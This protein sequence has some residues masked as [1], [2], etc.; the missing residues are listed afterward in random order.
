MATV[1]RPSKSLPDPG[2]A[3][4]AEP[5]RD[6]IT[7]ILAFLESTNIDEGNVDLTGSD[8]IL[9][10]ST[11]Q[12]ATGLKTWGQTTAASA[13]VIDVAIFQ[14][15][16]SSGTTSDNQGMR[17]SFKMDDDAGNL[18]EVG[19]IDLVETDVSSTTEDAEWQFHA[20]AAG[21]LTKSLTVSGTGTTS[22]LPLTV[23][24]NDTGHDVKFFGASSGAYMEWDESADQLRIMGAS[25]DATTS[26]GKLL[27]ATSLTDINAN[28]VLGKI[29][30]QA[31]HE[32][33]GTD[34]ITVAASI[35]AIAQGTF[36][37]G[38][39]ATDLIFY[40][41]HSEAATEKIRITSQGEIGI[42]GANYGSDGQVLTSGGAGA[43]PAWEDSTAG[44]ITGV[45]AG[46]GLSGGGT[47]G[48]V[49]LTVEAAQTVITSLLATDIKIGED[50]ETKIDFET[51]DE[52]HFFAADTE[53][54]YLADNIFGP[55]SDSDV[56]LG[57][58]GV[59][60]KDAFVDS[61]TVT[62]EVDGATL[63]ISG[64]ADIDG[65]TN[66]DAVDIDGAVQ[67]DATVSVGVDDQGYDVKF[68]GDTASAYLLWDTSADKLLTAGGASIDIVKDKLLIGGTAVTTTAAE[69]NVLDA[70]TGGTVAASKAVVVDSYKDVSSFR[71]VTL[72]G[73]LTTGSATFGGGYGDT[74]AT[75]SGAGVIQANGAITSDAAVTGATLVG[76]IS[77]AAQNSITS[78]S[79]L[80]TVGTMPSGTWS[81][82]IDGSCTMTLGSDATGDIYYRD[83]SGHLER[84]ASGADGYVLT[85]TGAG[86][87]PAWEAAT[88]GDITGVTAG[89]GLSGGG[90][91]GGVTLNIEAAQT[92]ITS[93]LA[94]DI[95][96]GEDD[97]TKIDFET[98]DEI[99][100]FAADT[101]QVYL[102]DNIFGPQSDSDVDLGTTGV[103]WKD[104][105]VDSITVTGEVDGATL[106][107]SGNADID[108]IT[109]LDAVDIDGAVQIDA[110]VS[111]GVDD[112]G[113]DV[114]FFGDTASA[115][116]L[117][118]TSADKLLTAGGASIDIVKD[119]LLIG[120][121]AVTTTAA[122]LNV[123]DAITGGT[124]AASKAVVVDSYKDVSS[125]RNVTLT[126][127]LTTGSAT[128]GG[129]Y[130][131]TGATISGAGVIQANGAITSDAA[132]TGATLVGT[133]STAAQNSIT[134]ASSLATVGTMP[135]GT[136]SGVIDGSCTM[137]LGSDATGDIYYRDAS[138]HLERLASGADGYVLTGT[139]AGSIPA[140]EAATTGDITGVT[141]GVGLS[142][143]GSSGG[144]T[145]TLDLSELSAVT[146][147]SGDWFATLDSDGANEQ[148]TTTDALATLFAG[149][150]LTASS[151]VIGVDASQTQ[152]TAV[153]TIATGTWQGTKVAS[154]YLDDDTAHLSGT[155]TFSGAKTFG[156]AD[157]V[158]ANGNGL[159][160]GHTAQQA[161]TGGSVHE[162]QVLGTALADSSMT[163]G[164]WSADATGPTLTFAKS[165]HATIGSRAVVQDN[166]IVGEILWTADDGVDLTN[167]F[168][169]IQVIVD[170]GSPAN[171][172][173]GMEMLFKV[174][175]TAGNAKNTLTLTSTQAEI[176]GTSN[177]LKIADASNNGTI[178]YSSRAFNF[179]DTTSG[180]TWMKIGDGSANG[181]VYIGDT[182]NGSMTNGLTINQGAADNEGLA[183]KSSDVN[184]GV[185]GA[186]ETDTY[187]SVKK[188]DAAS[189]GARLQAFTESDD[190]LV[191]FSCHLSD[192]TAKS[193][194]AVGS[195][196][197]DVYK[198][199]GTNTGTPGANSNLMTI[200]NG[201]VG[202]RFIFDADGDSHQDVGTAWTNFDGEE[203]AQVCRSVAHVM[204]ELAETSKGDVG[205]GVMV[206]SKFD[207]WGIDHK[208]SLIHMGLI[209]RLTPEEEVAGDRPLMNMT[210]LARVHNG[211][212][213]Q[214][215]IEIQQMKEDFAAQIDQRDTK[216]ALLEQRLNRLES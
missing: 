116:L 109:N 90:T 108:G 57:T 126:G 216:I 41:G 44:D 47:S 177:Q 54:V 30:F 9:G 151:A 28:D 183:L 195:I 89:T 124:V 22:H 11:A 170:D 205:A 7:N 102:A 75:I 163:L 148:L 135:S 42:G 141:A 39:N 153:G 2:D 33:G 197:N 132:V 143:G 179:V 69:L 81:G 16:P 62:G 45:T 133:I 49:T 74:G 93:L 106:D 213:W 50:D 99:H 138:G 66:L 152:I 212:I 137:T 164:R 27:L 131:D 12:T 144:V 3:L 96:I 24:V 103:R 117:W 70:I 34:A 125:F 118:D 65:I 188:H 184:H 114:K 166:D 175:D 180:N 60:W 142:G 6:Y 80:A 203:D 155:Q 107:I 58:T 136:W 215:H 172:A 128:F 92:G 29:D 169:R 193:T 48:G 72:T 43:A 159:V 88:A 67:I 110:T 199:D 157:V 31:P 97:E 192:N 55:Q 13:S 15:N 10:K 18:D 17:L 206:K 87:I 113:Y 26:T 68:F 112:Q 84:L 83:A 95:K 165:R 140:W 187:L 182:A 51:A 147:A 115:Y 8:G 37:A 85:G 53:Q 56:D 82:V 100:F 171:N 59:R 196:V 191:L 161:T 130:G 129:G 173:V 198:G 207:Q 78:A 150:G 105:F 32:A 185:T 76:T 19:T 23:G 63:D 204:T 190:A 14:W 77:T 145:L 71:N 178:G 208:E 98:A 86:S 139:G 127:A 104:A 5:I 79:S 20:V 176:T 174:S 121:T 64:N 181:A 94:T 189:G 167:Q 156:S 134:S 162:L 61:I 122:E 160:V 91:S 4:D 1:T 21:S 201:G 120:G 149:T 146:P 158:V 168:A 194:S 119:K 73:A 52:I 38:V 111:V 25:A 209:P 211:A 186:A 123:L 35:Q 210:Q 200:R 40:T 46:T 214:T 36:A 154:A 202:V 101:E